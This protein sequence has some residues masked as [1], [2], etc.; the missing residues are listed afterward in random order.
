MLL[1]LTKYRNVGYDEIVLQDHPIGYWKAD[2]PS[3]STM[4]DSSGNGHNGTYSGTVHLNQSPLRAGAIASI[5]MTS[6]SYAARVTVSGG[7]GI[8]AGE[9]FTLEAIIKKTAGAGTTGT[10]Y[11][12]VIGYGANIPEQ[13]GLVYRH[14]TNNSKAT[15]K[16]YTFTEVISPN[17]TQGTIVI[18][19]MTY[20]VASP[21]NITKIYENG[22]LV[23]SGTQTNNSSDTPPLN[24]LGCP[25]FSSSTGIKAQASDFAMYDYALS[26]ARCLVHAQAAGLA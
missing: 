25:N 1:G 6:L 10:A 19:Q 16:F 20:E 21:N 17:E 4:I 23:A 15:A 7:L 14:G 24:F 26:A 5:S 2:E 13:P 8:S 18:L 22:V 9:P 12:G 11:G 3:G